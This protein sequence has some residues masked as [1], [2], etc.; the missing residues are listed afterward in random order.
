M[1]KG[2]KDNSGFSALSFIWRLLGAL[3]IV[4][5]TFN[6]SG[7][8]AYHWISGA[9]TNGAFGPEHLL[10]IGLLLIGWS[11]FW[12]ATWRALDPF[13]V[14]LV[15]IVLAS[16]VWLFIDLGWLSAQSTS[17]KAWIGLVCLAIV[18]A[19]GASWS[20]IWRRITGQVNVEHVED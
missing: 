13:G 10:V 6:P 12:F 14:L 7:Y 18:L 15:A 8:S 5:L 19:V 4:L 9:V 1:P 2:D 17:S 3:T 11:V 16:L 20:H